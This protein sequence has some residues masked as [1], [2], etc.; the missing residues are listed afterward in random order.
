MKFVVLSSVFSC[1]LLAILRD[2]GDREP[3]H[4]FWCQEWDKNSPCAFISHLRHNWAAQLLF[5]ATNPDYDS[6]TLEDLR[7]E[8]SRRPIAFISKDG[9]RTLASKLRVHDKLMSI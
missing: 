7:T 9:I 6:W 1:S 4:N 2:P 8:A 3:S 5:L